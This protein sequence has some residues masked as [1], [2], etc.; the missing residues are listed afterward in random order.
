[1]RNALQHSSQL[2]HFFK[3]L[4]SIRKVF[5]GLRN[6]ARDEILT[7]VLESNTELLSVNLIGDDGL[8]GRQV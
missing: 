4:L 1:M 5:V 7:S 6:G 2:S 3:R 8:Y